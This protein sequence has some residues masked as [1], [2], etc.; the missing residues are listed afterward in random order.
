MMRTSA[1]RHVSRSGVVAVVAWFGVVVLVALVVHTLP[2]A[3]AGAECDP[4]DK[5][6][7]PDVDKATGNFNVPEKA[8]DGF[9]FR[10]AESDPADSKHFV[11][12]AFL[13]DDEREGWYK[14]PRNVVASLPATLT[15]A[16]EHGIDEGGGLTVTGTVSRTAVGTTAA[17]VTVCAAI[18]PAAI[19]NFHPGRYQGR[20]I[21]RAENFQDVKI[22]ILVTLRDSPT[23]ALL[24]GFVGVA[25]GLLVKMLTDLAAAARTSNPG[26]LHALREYVDWGLPVTI[27]LGILAG[28]LGY[29]ELY[30]ANPTWGSTGTDAMKLFGTCFGFQLG[31]V[32]SIDVAR[33]MV[34]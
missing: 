28:W 31:A 13:D 14:T 11:I 22:P 19:P 30:D 24:Y 15:S 25:L 8:E 34:G 10:F 5:M 33:R 26:P 9:R 16:E 18:D 21:L 27:L 6:V 3:A 4:P 12:D 1:T 20:V 2:A 7:E 29:A 23:E 32:G 17:A